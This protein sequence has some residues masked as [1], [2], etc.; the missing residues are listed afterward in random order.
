MPCCADTGSDSGV[1]AP[2][3]AGAFYPTAEAGPGSGSI[4]G[5][6]VS[7]PQRR[8]LPVFS[9]VTVHAQPLPN[10]V[11]R[12]AH[13]MAQAAATGRALAHLWEG[14]PGWA[15]PRSY[16]RAPA[17]PVH[18]QA[19][20][21]RAS[22]GGLVP[23]G[24][25]LLNVSLV[26]CCDHGV[27]TS[28]AIYLALCDA[29][30]AA[31]AQLDIVAAARAVEGS[32]C[33]GRYNLAAGGRKVAGIAQAWRRIAGAQ[34]VLAHAVLLVDA[35]VEA[36]TAQ[37]NAVERALGRPQ[38]Y[39]ATAATTIARLWCARHGRADAPEGF[40]R[41]VRAAVAQRFAGATT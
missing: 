27:G 23:M 39:R 41:T 4:P 30:C 6:G 34:V 3:P 13:W 29:L 37:A 7:R 35:D 1:V 14:T 10:G 2:A 25:G 40:G 33:D 15:V 11:E 21:I 16:T 18:G 22:G 36:L 24:P 26:W 19:L 32:L 31:L 17:W 20:R 5:A 9:A 12:E 8:A 28:D 38:R